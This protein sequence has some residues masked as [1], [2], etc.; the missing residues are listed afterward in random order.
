MFIITVLHKSKDRRVCDNFFG[1]SLINVFGKILERVIQN[2]FVTYCEDTPRVL[3]TSQFGFCSARSTQDCILL[4]RLISSSAMEMQCN[5]YKYFVDLTK[6][7]DK[8]TRDLLWHILKLRGFPP[9]II[10]L[11]RGLMV[12]S[13]AY[14]RVN[15]ILADPFDLECGLKQ[16]LVSAP[17][18]FNICFGAIIEIFQKEVLKNNGGI[19]LKLFFFLKKSI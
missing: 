14:V 5:L 16:G 11:V 1:I 17:L 7:Y 6:T 2:R 12:G 19:K 18:L 9:E 13:K 4:S 8:V 15:G 10:A 3:P